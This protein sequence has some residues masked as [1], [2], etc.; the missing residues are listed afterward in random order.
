MAFRNRPPSFLEFLPSVHHSKEDD[1][2][3]KRLFPTQATYSMAFVPSKVFPQV[4]RGEG[5]VPRIVFPKAITLDSW[6]HTQTAAH[7]CWCD[8]EVRTVVSSS[9]FS[10][11]SSTSLL[12]ISA[13][14]VSIIP[15]TS[16]SLQHDRMASQRWLRD[17]DHCPLSLL[18]LVII[19][20][21]SFSEYKVGERSKSTRVLWIAGCCSCSK[22]NVWPRY[23]EFRLDGLKLLSTTTKQLQLVS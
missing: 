14:A 16:K 5:E 19:H 23:T 6:F 7:S 10:A 18:L 8:T 4:N 2:K 11:P 13:T 21:R 20:C 17:R 9:S 12:S 22:R 15:E 3:R 1:S